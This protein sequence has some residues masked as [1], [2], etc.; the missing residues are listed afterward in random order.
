[1]VP[2]ANARAADNEMRQAALCMK[3]LAI[4]EDIAHASLGSNQRLLSVA[5]DFSPQSINV[6][7]H[8]IGIGPDSHTPHLV[9]DHRAGQHE[10]RIPA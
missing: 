6:D 9:E 7:I 8:D 1:M 5:I 2:H 4:F 10:A 3:G